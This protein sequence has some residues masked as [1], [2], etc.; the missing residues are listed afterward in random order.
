MQIEQLVVDSM[1]ATT[2]ED[3]GASTPIHIEIVCEEIEF[4]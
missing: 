2:T 4:L 1:N 3:Q